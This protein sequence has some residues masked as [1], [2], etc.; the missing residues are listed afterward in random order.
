METPLL[1]EI[2]ITLIPG[3]GDVN[4]KKLI[5]WCGSAEEV[6]KSSAK[7]LRAVPGIG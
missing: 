1:Y 3:I 6:F 4:G 2:G 7:T 5:Q